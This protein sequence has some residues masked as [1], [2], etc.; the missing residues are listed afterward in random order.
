MEAPGDGL[1]WLVAFINGFSRVHV[2]AGFHRWAKLL[3]M[4]F[5]TRNA[6]C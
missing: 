5:F 3:E 2:V 6:F 4:N 1:L